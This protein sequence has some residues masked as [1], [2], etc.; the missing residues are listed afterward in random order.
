MPNYEAE[1]NNRQRVP[2]SAEIAARWQA[3]SA[4]YTRSAHAELDLPYGA[5]ARQRYSAPAGRARR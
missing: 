4:A 5:G 2:E 3:A 1:Y